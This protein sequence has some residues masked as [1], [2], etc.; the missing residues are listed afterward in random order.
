MM[1][2]LEEYPKMKDMLRLILFQGRRVSYN[3][4]H[5]AINLAAIFGYVVRRDGC[6]QV[7]NRIYEMRLYQSLLSEEEL[8]NAIGNEAER[9]RSFFCCT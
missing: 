5:P 6:V 2:H 4:D 8:T 7:A 3:P 1:R 9:D